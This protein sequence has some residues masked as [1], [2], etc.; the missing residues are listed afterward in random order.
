MII[1]VDSNFV[2]KSLTEG[3]KSH[4]GVNNQIHKCKNLMRRDWEIRL[5]HVFLS[6]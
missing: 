5:S 6:K 2:A 4:M 3:D 1:E